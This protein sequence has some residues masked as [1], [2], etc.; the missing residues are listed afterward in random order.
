MNEINTPAKLEVEVASPS[1]DRIKVI[2]S[3][4]FLAGL[5][6]WTLRQIS[7]PDAAPA[8]APLTEFS[9]ARAMKQLRVIAR[10]PHP[11]GSSEEARVRDYLLS[12]LTA[13]QRVAVE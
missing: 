4:L 11:I 1:V 2:L 8:S 5:I 12:E 9:S 6:L 10:N 3:S 7:P 13:L